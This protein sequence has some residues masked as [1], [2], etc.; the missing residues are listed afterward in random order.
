MIAA[1]SPASGE[2][3]SHALQ[4]H[5][6][7]ARFVHLGTDGLEAAIEGDAPDVLLVAG[8]VDP[9]T[10][11]QLQGLRDR[12]PGLRVLVLDG[13]PDRD[14]PAPIADCERV[15]VQIGLRRLAAVV[16]GRRSALPQPRSRS[17]D[18]G[19][20]RGHARQP[21]PL[22]RLTRRERE[23]LRALMAGMSR[24]DIAGHLAISPHTVRTHLQHAFAKLGASSQLEA[25]SIALRGGLRPAGSD[26]TA[27]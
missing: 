16:A 26:G 13:E 11:I 24:D 1:A 25:V 2:A 10:A 8:P 27:P 4:S 6:H 3:L 23:V 19:R 7:S 17:P 5:G 22:A 12:Q 21:D 9:A 15:P 14:L 20:G 18:P